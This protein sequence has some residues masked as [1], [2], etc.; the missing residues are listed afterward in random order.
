MS[1]SHYIKNIIQIQP[2]S[3]KS[4]FKKRMKLPANF[5]L[6]KRLQPTPCRPKIVKNPAI[7]VELQDFWSCQADSNCRPHPYQGC[8]LPT[9]PQQHMATRN[10]LEPSTSSVTGQ[11]SN[12][13]NYRAIW[14]GQK[15]LN[16]RHVVLETTALP[17]E[18]Y[19]Y[20]PAAF[21]CLSDFLS[22]SIIIPD[23]PRDV[24]T[25]FLFFRHM[26]KSSQTPIPMRFFA[27]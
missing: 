9:E 18:L 6:P 25:F 11:R 17:T 16:P 26:Q 13:L 5:L 12:Q 2:R 24:N 23:Y 8:A 4:N 3:V 7:H 15:D 14:Q 27:D 22:A 10:G 1:K 21:G 20:F 19:P